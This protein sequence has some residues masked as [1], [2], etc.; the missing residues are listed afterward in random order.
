LKFQTHPSKNIL[1]ME[2]Y[3]IPSLDEPNKNDAWFVG[4]RCIAQEG[5]DTEE[6]K[7]IFL[8]KSRS[9]LRTRLEKLRQPFKPLPFLTT[10]CEYVLEIEEVLD[11][12]TRGCVLEMKD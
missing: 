3:T 4:D 7:R 12:W 9:A 1:R 10:T 8:V 6:W 5:V 2:G 11:C